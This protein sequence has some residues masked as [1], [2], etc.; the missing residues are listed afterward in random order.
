MFKPIIHYD[1]GMEEAILG[2]CILEKFSFSHTLGILNE[3][4]LYYDSHKIVYGALLE[5]WNDGIAI[6]MLTLASYLVRQK[7]HEKIDDINTPAFICRLTNSVVSSANIQTHCLIVR[8]LYAERELLRL[9]NSP[10]DTSVDVL[11]RTAR[12]QQELYK[13]TQIKISDDWKHISEVVYQLS[14]HMDNVKDKEIV[15]ITSGFYDFDLV[16]GGF[17]NSQLII[18]AARPSVGKSALLGKFCVQAALQ[19]KHVGIISLEMSNV[20]LGA[21]FGSLVSETEFYKIFRNKL[22]EDFEHERVYK[23]LGELS[24][25]SIHISDKTNVNI[26]DIRAKASQLKSRGELDILFIDYLQLVESDES[27]KHYNREQEVSK[28]SRGLKLLAKELNIP[29]ICLAQL[30]RESEKMA[31]KKPA[32]H[33][34]RESGA[35]EQ[36]ADGVIFLHRDWKAGIETNQE[37]GSTEHEADLIIA[38][39]RNGELKEFKI[40]FD[41]GKMNFYDKKQNYSPF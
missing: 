5:M 22:N 23:K 24:E 17:G 20:E 39:W 15:G 26:N 2:A 8:Q 31:N 34:L 28:M 12:I 33:H 1:K 32:L 25:Y 10:V 11:D 38:K 35:I 37:G 21:R 4:C 3:D 36:D 9:Q 18:L 19:K 30:N 13:I 29:I 6:D 40:G 41:G 27:Q 16:T 7:K 14:L